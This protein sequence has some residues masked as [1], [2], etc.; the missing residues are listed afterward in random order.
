VYRLSQNELLTPVP[1]FQAYAQDVA[2][3]GGEAP[4]GPDDDAWLLLAQ[5]LARAG[6]A[7][8][9]G[10]SAVLLGGGQVIAGM[11]GVAPLCGVGQALVVV[12]GG[13]DGY[14]AEGSHAAAQQIVEATQLVA[15]AQERAGAFMLA[16]TTL[17]ALREAL[18]PLL[19][20]RARGLILAQQ[21]RAARQLGAIASAAALYRE[22]ARAAR[23][24]RAPDVAARALLGSGVLANMR[25]N[26]PEART[27][28]KRALTAGK[29]SGVTEFSRAAHHGLLIAAIAAQDVDTA[30]EHGWAAM[31]GTPDGAGD[32]RAE[33][34]INLANVGSLAGEHR[35]SLGA[36]L[37]ALELST[38]AR[39]C[40]PAIGTAVV[41]AGHLGERRLLEH[42]TREAKRI[43]DRAGQPFEA[44]SVL[45][46][47]AEA[48]AILGDDAATELADGALA[49]AEAGG[50]YELATRAE[51]VRR[52]RAEAQV[53]VPSVTNQPHW[54]PAQSHAEWPAAAAPV[55]V[56]STRAR[57]VVRSLEALSM[58]RFTVE[59]P[60]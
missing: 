56:R 58:D 60:C 45:L 21:G 40:L 50:F 24:G 31:L 42:L 52:A 9:A 3:L 46:A 51:K 2:R 22:A 23:S 47:L 18:A 8:R 44:A 20:D 57:A 10:R 54:A 16:F 53:A 43:C 26:Y 32:E 34:L 13:L 5:T 19:D 12:A 36:S 7:T 33:I 1:P 6:T 59:A 4:I 35:A 41:A 48:H 28:F 37:R 11:D 39:V 30:L 38:A 29:R 27:F 15:A 14:E 55:V 17:A 25:G 49:A